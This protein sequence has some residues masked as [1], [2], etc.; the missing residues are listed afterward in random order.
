MCPHYYREEEF[1]L[2]SKFYV[3]SVLRH[4]V[5]HYCDGPFSLSDAVRT[6]HHERSCDDRAAVWEKTSSGEWFLWN[7][8]ASPP[9]RLFSYD[10]AVTKYSMHHCEPKM[11]PSIL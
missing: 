7:D 6:A 2:G 4:Y 11:Y 3:L 1:N 10:E 5:G 9:C 8:V